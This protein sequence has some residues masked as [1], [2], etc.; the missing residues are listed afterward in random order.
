LS[1][2]FGA[3]IRMIEATVIQRLFDGGVDNREHA[4]EVFE[5]HINDVVKE[6][7]ED[8]LLVYDVST[9]WAPLCAFLGVAA[10]DGIPFPRG[11]GVEDF[12]REEG[13][14]MRRLIMGSMLRR[15]K[16]SA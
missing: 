3:F 13:D 16:A 1:P 6:I 15:S 7:P 11:N 12:R 2:D 8:R 4:I 10:P 14:R 9:G 5:R